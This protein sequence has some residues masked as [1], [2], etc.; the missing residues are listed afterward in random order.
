MENCICLSAFSFLRL[1]SGTWRS[2]FSLCSFTFLKHKPAHCLLTESFS[3][4]VSSSQTEEPSSAAKMSV[5]RQRPKQIHCIIGFAA[6]RSKWMKTVLR[7]SFPWC[8]QRVQFGSCV[9]PVK[10]WWNKDL[11]VSTC[12][13]AAHEIWRLSCR[14]T[15]E[16]PVINVREKLRDDYLSMSLLIRLHIVLFRLKWTNTKLFYISSEEKELVEIT[17]F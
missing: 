11:T 1:H 16:S 2:P 6:K 17:K 12:Y 10:V 13:G 4:L 14:K 3:L 9:S 5:K 15:F 7:P 8:L